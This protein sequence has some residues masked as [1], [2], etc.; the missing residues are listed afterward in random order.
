MNYQRILQ[1]E[2]L[3]ESTPKFDENIGTKNVLDLFKINRQLKFHTEVKKLRKIKINKENSIDSFENLTN[4]VDKKVK[5]NKPLKS[6][7]FENVSDNFY[8]NTLDI[9]DLTKV[10]IGTKTGV[11]II[12]GS[13]EM[14]EERFTRFHFDSANEIYTVKFLNSN[15]IIFS[16]SNCT[17][18]IKDLNK[19]IEILKF[20]SIGRKFL[21]IDTV[22]N[23][24]NILFLGSDNSNVDFYDIRQK[25]KIRNLI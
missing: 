9:F 17:L 22:R 3:E 11:D 16:D 7:Q 12:D 19:E 23:E 20:D 4:E 21:T 24:E 25:N 14:N 18:K 8:L 2:I 13:S 10:A 15:K 6:Y 1:S 5:I